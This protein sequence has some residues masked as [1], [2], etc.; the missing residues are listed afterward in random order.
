[1]AAYQR[2]DGESTIPFSH[3]NK[4][5]KNQT[6]KVPEEL[7][8][9]PKISIKNYKPSPI[10]KHPITVDSFD[11]S[12]INENHVKA[13]A[14]DNAFYFIR[15]DMEKRIGW[16]DF[17]QRGKCSSKSTIGHMPMILNPAHE[18]DTLNLVIRRCMS[19][20]S[21]FG[22]KYTL[23]TVDQQ[24][25]CKLHAIIS[26]TPEFQHKV[27]VRLGGLHIFLNFQRIM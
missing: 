14:A 21:Y 4:F 7:T 3:I 6:L 27:F 13:K 10:T 16:T 11:N 1:M 23:L 5:S 25:F 12:E 18:Y 20:S 17:N 24:L 15:N 9:I 2:S 19:I 8:Q 26:N 22:Q